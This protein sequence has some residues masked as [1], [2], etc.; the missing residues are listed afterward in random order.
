MGDL[1]FTQYFYDDLGRISYTVSGS[2]RVDVETTIASLPADISSL[3][4]T[5]AE[6]L[7]ASGMSIAVYDTAE[8]R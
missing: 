6:T 8:N 7:L 5:D 4:V 3:T 1:S 2:N